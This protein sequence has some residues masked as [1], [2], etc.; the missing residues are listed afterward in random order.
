[1]T[2]AGALAEGPGAEGLGGVGGAA[3]A[4]RVS[5]IFRHQRAMIS[6]AIINIPAM[7]THR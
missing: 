7:V 1:M 3:L 5:S 4:R 2:E 6:T